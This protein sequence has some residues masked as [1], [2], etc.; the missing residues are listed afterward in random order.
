V[1]DDEYYSHDVDKR[2]PVFTD[3]EEDGGLLSFLVFDS[4]FYSVAVSCDCDMIISQSI[5]NEL[6][7]V[8]QSRRLLLG[9]FT[10]L[11]VYSWK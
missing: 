1:F 9:H 3:D 4:N 7:I 8:A 5:K 10:Q 2:K 6:I 11:V